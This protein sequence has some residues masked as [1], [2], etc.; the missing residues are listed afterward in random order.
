MSQDAITSRIVCI[1]L[2]VA[3]ALLGVVSLFGSLS[4][5]MVK[6][7]DYVSQ[8]FIK[9]DEELLNEI[10]SALLEECTDMPL[11]AEAFAAALDTDAADRVLYKASRNIILCYDMDFSDD[12]EL[13]SFFSDGMEKYCDE[14]NISVK[15]SDLNACASLAVDVSNEVLS[16]GVS[17]NIRLFRAVAGKSLAIKFVLCGALCAV[18]IVL[19]HMFN[20]GRHKKYI[21]YSTAL[22]SAGLLFVFVT[23]LVKSRHYIDNFNFC[24]FEI[25]DK[26]I[27]DVLNS[28]LFIY[29]I[30]GV[31]CV[32]AGVIMMVYNYKYYVKRK[33]INE[34][35][36]RVNLELKDAYM[37]H[38]NNNKKKESKKTQE[39]S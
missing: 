32:A 17:K 25:Y 28:S 29:P 16:S 11:P 15:S 30:I 34:E 4:T 20:K 12:T 2:A 3:A 39:E 5:G 26:A 23:F 8:K 37:Q 6:S 24:A 7:V 38:F 10:N 35:E 1:I 33:Q 14:N 27:K 21:Y 18:C 13:Y 31:I 22:I 9:Y 19:I 36:K